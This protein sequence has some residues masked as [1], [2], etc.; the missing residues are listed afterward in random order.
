MCLKSCGFVI[1][2]SF[3]KTEYGN[4]KGLQ[5]STGSTSLLYGWGPESVPWDLLGSRQQGTASE[6]LD[7][8]N[9]DSGG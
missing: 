9:L 7:I 3:I 8:S 2:K 5:N 4:Q 6:P 1:N